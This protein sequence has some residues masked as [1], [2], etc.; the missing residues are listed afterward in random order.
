MP[1]PHVTEDSHLGSVDLSF[2]TAKTWLNLLRQS[3]E[4]KTGISGK[5]ASFPF[6]FG[7][8]QGRWHFWPQLTVHDGFLTC[9][10]L[11]L[12]FLSIDRKDCMRFQLAAAVL[13]FGSTFPSFVGCEPPPPP[14]A[15]QPP[16]VS[17]MHPEQREL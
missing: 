4:S 6:R 17:V 2:L 13:L 14:A 1:L 16:K 3:V 11:Q 15:P 8:L 7:T 9:A 10:E 5:L 12:H